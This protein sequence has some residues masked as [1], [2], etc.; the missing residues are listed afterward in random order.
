MSGPFKMS[1]SQ[2]LGKGNQ[3][4][5]LNEEMSN[6]EKAKADGA[7]E[8]T[9]QKLKDQENKAAD[10]TVGKKKMDEETDPTRKQNLT[11]YI[12]ENE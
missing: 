6:S 10:F 1:G 3:S 8:A 9:I 7:S 5:G 12:K 11:T 4:K 2:F